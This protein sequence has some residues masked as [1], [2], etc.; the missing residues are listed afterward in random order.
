MSEQRRPR[1][2]D[3]CAPIEKASPTRWSASGPGDRIASARDVAI[4]FREDCRTLRD[5]LQLE[6]VVAQYYLRIRDVRTTGGVP[7]GDVVGGSVVAELE[8][9]ADSLSHAILRGLAHLGAG[10]AAKR[11]AEAVTRLTEQAIG[12]P[13]QFADVCKASALGAWRTRASGLDSEYALFADFEHPH[14]PRHA[15]ALFVEPRGRGIVK[16]IGLLGAMSE[17]DPG[18]PFHPK[19]LEPVAISHAAVLIRDLLEHSYGP[20]AADTDDFR[21]LIASARARTLRVSRLS[22]PPAATPSCRPTRRRW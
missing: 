13:Q 15:I 12:L 9:E 22:E 2:P 5:S 20:L 17:L 4:Y 21:V 19:A 6:M 1:N 8:R 11:S 7:V 18:E 3:R 10:E 16:H 14:G